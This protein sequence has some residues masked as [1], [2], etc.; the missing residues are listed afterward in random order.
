MTKMKKKNTR[1]EI[2]TTNNIKWKEIIKK[3]NLSMKRS[4]QKKKKPV[5]WEPK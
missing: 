4:G 2:K 3:E 5:T 1:S